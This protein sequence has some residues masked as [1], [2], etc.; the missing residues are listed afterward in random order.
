MN[1]F[2]DYTNIIRELLKHKDMRYIGSTLTDWKKVFKD[3]FK[4]VLANNKEKTSDQKL[5]VLET[6]RWQLLDQVELTGTD[7]DYTELNIWSYDYIL[8]KSKDQGS[9]EKI[10]LGGLLLGLGLW[11]LKRK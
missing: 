1:L 8:K 6:A 2:D 10:L 4:E 7:Q 5:A 11:A 3:T 9:A